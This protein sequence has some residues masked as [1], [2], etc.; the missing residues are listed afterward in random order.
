MA[1]LARRVEAGADDAE[2][3]GTCDGAEAAEN[4]LLHL[5]HAHGAF[6]PSCPYR[7]RKKRRIR[8]PSAQLVIIRV[9]HP[10]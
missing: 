10:A 5:G 8:T 6:G 1:L 4:F 3:V 7:E 2:I 9:Y